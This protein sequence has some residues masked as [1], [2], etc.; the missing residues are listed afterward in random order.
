MIERRLARY[1]RIPGEREEPWGPR[2]GRTRVDSRSDLDHKS[3]QI[4]LRS[5]SRRAEARADIPDRV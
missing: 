4:W 2:A 1:A 3:V 5:M